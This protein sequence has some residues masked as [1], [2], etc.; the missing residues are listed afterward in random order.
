VYGPDND[1]IGDHRLDALMLALGGLFLE[2]SMYSPSSIAQSAPAS[3]TKNYLDRRAENLGSD[4]LHAA[5]VVRM[6]NKEAPGIHAT[7]MEIHR[8]GGGDPRHAGSILE[9]GKASQRGWF[10]KRQPQKRGDLAGRGAN[11]RLEK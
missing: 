6:F 9:A 3:L 4:R 10:K 8:Q 7:V 2:K 5:D 1:R 11:S